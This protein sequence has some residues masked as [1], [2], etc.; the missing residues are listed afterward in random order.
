LTAT[1]R[2][3]LLARIKDPKDSDAWRQFERLYSPLLYRYARG[4]GLARHD[5]EEVRD[6]CLEVIVRKIGEF[7][8]DRHKGGFK[9]WLFRMV[10]HKVTD[11]HRKR[12]EVHADSKDLR[13]LV[14]PEPTPDELWEQTWQYEHL[15]FGVEQVR[16]EVAERDFQA[17]RMLVTD[18][19]S[20]AEVCRRLDLNPNQVYKAKARVLRRVREQLI[21]MDPEL[22]P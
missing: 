19:C 15:K 8:Y 22:A 17:F 12:R 10:S 13:A 20:V 21:A 7:E 11:L 5:A 6:Q 18:E 4:R 14:D 9:N 16:N 3:T 1:P 2:C